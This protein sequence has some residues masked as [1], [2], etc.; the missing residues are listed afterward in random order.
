MSGC[1]A[2]SGRAS[3]RADARSRRA[4]S[5]IQLRREARRSFRNAGTAEESIDKTLKKLGDVYEALC[6]A[7]LLMLD[8][9]LD[10]W[11]RIVSH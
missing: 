3:A 6:G 2:S 10:A 1:D 5:L 9:D 8:G 7:V 4:G 11:W